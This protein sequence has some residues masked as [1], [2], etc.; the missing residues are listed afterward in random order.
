MYIDKLIFEKLK[1]F[2]FNITRNKMIE[3]TF[4]E[5]LNE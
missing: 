4:F 5:N 3:P 1:T 2:D